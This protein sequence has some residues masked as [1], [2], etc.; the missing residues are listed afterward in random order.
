MKYLK[1]QSESDPTKSYTIKKTV[2]GWRCSCPSFRFRGHC[3]HIDKVLEDP[4]K[5]NIDSNRKIKKEYKKYIQDGKDLIDLY[6]ESF[7]A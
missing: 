7:E 3:K 4:H 2:L 1:I 6:D 5:V